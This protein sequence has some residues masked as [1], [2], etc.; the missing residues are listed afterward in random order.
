MTMRKK[1]LAA[2]NQNDGIIPFT[3]KSDPEA[4][5]ETF[6]FSKSAFKRALG[7]LLKEKKVVQRDGKT[8]LF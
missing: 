4:I 8:Y 1:I 6:G 2:L 5:R 3:D 7:K